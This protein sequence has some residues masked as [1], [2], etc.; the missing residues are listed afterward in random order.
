MK[1][2]ILG[3]VALVL[4]VGA[5]AYVFRRPL[6][7]T[8]IPRVVAGNMLSNRLDE[9]PDGLHVGLCGAGSPLP[10]PVR[11][12]PC[13]AVAAGDRLFIVDAGSGTSRNLGR[14]GLPHGQIEGILL[15][16]FHSDHIDGLGE[17]LMQRWV[18]GSHTLPTPIHGPDGVEDVVQGFNLAYKNDAIARTAHHGSDIVPPSGTG[19]RAV[20]FAVPAP[21]DGVKIVDDDLTI[22]A[23]VVD[24]DPVRPAVGYRFDY[25]GRSVLV[26]GDTDKSE[27]VAKFGQGVDL[28]VHEALSPEL[29]NLLT[30]GA[31]NAGRPK[32]EKITTDILDYHASPV[33]VAE[34]ARDAGAQELLFY[35]I[36]PPLLLP[37]MEEIFVEGVA[38]T[39]DGPFTVGKD[40]TFM[41]LPAGSTEITKQ[42]LF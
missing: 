8:I 2:M 29:V 30:E 11:S 13:V 35:H 1:K 24:H 21:G 16:H 38:D 41:S 40:G 42:E 33:E 12:G 15:T 14:M 27:N 19:A 26:S 22:T 4:V 17:M 9:L 3:L 5:L 37:T 7:M 10:D 23:F 32:L 39:Y 36:V 28:M 6:T 31:R 34:T 18:N 25:K 20:P